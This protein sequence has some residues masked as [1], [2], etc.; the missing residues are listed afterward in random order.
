[1]SKLLR[2]SIACG[3]YLCGQRRFLGTALGCLSLAVLVPLSVSACTGGAPSTTPTSFSPGGTAPA[4]SAGSTASVTTPSAGAT[5][6]TVSATTPT[7]SATTPSVSASPSP[8]PS[9]SASPFPAGAP[10]TGGGGTAGFQD[11][12]LLCLGILAILAG[13]GSIAYRR[14]VMRNRRL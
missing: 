2:A 13:A 14:K 4:T 3:S 1:M 8:S 11:A 6:P 5:T 10:A 7:V 9:P 12:L